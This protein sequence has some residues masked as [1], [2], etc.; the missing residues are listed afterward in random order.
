M[1]F[2]ITITSYQREKHLDRLLRQIE[3]MKGSYDI[4]GVIIVDHCNY[5]Y[6][7]GWNM[8]NLGQH[9]GRKGF[10]QIMN[11][12]FG[13]MKKH[14]FKYY[15]NFQDDIILTD[16]FFTKCAKIWD[17]IKDDNKLILDLRNDE[18][19][20]RSLWGIYPVKIVTFNK[21]KYY[22]SQWFD[23]VFMSDSRIKK[24][25][26]TLEYANIDSSSGI[27]RQL[28]KRFRKKGFNMYHYCETLVNHGHCESLMNPETRK[29]EKLIC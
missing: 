2:Y 9:Y 14:D 27:A 5:S 26:P 28:T 12:A 4:G 6:K 7:E 19:A 17:N 18:R 8:I 29:K 10:Y 25:M 1:D 11:L 22:L 24:V 16:D 3:D 13:T 15:L 21:K 20:G 23:L